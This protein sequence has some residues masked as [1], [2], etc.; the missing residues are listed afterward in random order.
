ML[1][2]AIR[3]KRRARILRNI[4]AG[5][6]ITVRKM[7]TLHGW[8]SRPNRPAGRRMQFTDRMSRPGGTPGQRPT[9]PTPVHGGGRFTP[10]L[11]SGAA[12]VSVLRR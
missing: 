7:R 2:G 5:L 9:R 6:S 3:R 11:G 10:P 8:I 1:V 12:L 4:P